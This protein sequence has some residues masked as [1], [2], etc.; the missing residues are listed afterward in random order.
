MVRF[1]DWLDI[2]SIFE[3][4]ERESLADQ[5]LLESLDLIISHLN[6]S[7]D[8]DDDDDTPEPEMG[9]ENA[10]PIFD[11]TKGPSKT[12]RLKA[13]S[14][15][16]KAIKDNSIKQ[17]ALKIERLAAKKKM[18]DEDSLD[19]PDITEVIDDLVDLGYFRNKEAGDSVRKKIA[20][21]HEH[22][23]DEDP[24]QK[25]LKKAAE[26]EAAQAEKQ[27]R[28]KLSEAVSETDND[29]LH[30]SSGNID[31][32]KKSLYEN[33]V[34]LFGDRFDSVAARNQ[35]HTGSGVGHQTYEADEL[36]SSLFVYFMERFSKRPMKDG[37]PQPWDSRPDQFLFPDE[38]SDEPYDHLLKYIHKAITHTASKERRKKAKAF[39]PAVRTASRNSGIHSSKDEKSKIIRSDL[40]S[41]NLGFYKDYIDAASRRPLADRKAGEDIVQ[42]S[43]K[44]DKTRLGIMKAIEYEVNSH[45]S[46][47]E[48]LSMDPS[49]IESTLSSY[50][51]N[52]LKRGER[53]VTYASSL[54]G[55]DDDSSV[56]D[57]LSR[58][59]SHV[60]GSEDEKETSDAGFSSVAA[61]DSSVAHDS[62]DMR[63][64][65]DFFMPYVVRS[66]KELASSN[67][68]H[69]FA[70]CIKFGISC[71]I[72]SKAKSIRG[73]P[74]NVPEIVTVTDPDTTNP[75]IDENFKKY[76]KHMLSDE[77]KQSWAHWDHF[78]ATDKKGQPT[79]ILPENSFCRIIFDRLAAVSGVANNTTVSLIWGNM[80]ET[81]PNT[82]RFNPH[83]FGANGTPT[84][85]VDP[86][87]PKL[88][89]YDQSRIQE[90]LLGTA[91]SSGSISWLCNKVF[92]MI[93][94]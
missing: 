36:A 40:A 44:D 14:E 32:A 90:I 27:L 94:F 13:I 8:D 92:D 10:E 21:R 15:A 83:D 57:I 66:V 18:I 23:D 52:F 11:T 80:Q 35:R 78:G 6:E 74:V 81:S 53:S 48:F 43:N 4:I 30:N 73:T 68:Q 25:K 64:F 82:Y 7:L 19:S 42:A 24:A 46:S 1:S 16:I 9:D 69:A 38:D 93:K 71:T 70:L 87:K 65:S 50:M 59:M 3:S 62:P 41:D 75:Q 60:Q 72:R 77:S 76:L 22:Y 34:G 47:L 29:V 89:G 85:K 49:N 26:S 84:F 28:E 39:N 79:K 88:F 91:N 17:R 51:N 45:P 31:D 86:N 2:S 67:P 54:G 37:K 20:S 63:L 5:A 58:N 55:N 56:D 61:R 12:E 33:L